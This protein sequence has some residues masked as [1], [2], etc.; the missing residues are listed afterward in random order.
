MAA[1]APKKRGGLKPLS[2]RIEMPRNHWLPTLKYVQVATHSRCN[3]DCSFCPYVESAHAA[4][5]GMMTDA[6]WHKILSNLVP[7][8]DTLLKFCPY[9]M[10]EPLIDKSIFAKIDD[11]YRVFPNICVEISTN[12]A[13]LTDSTIDKLLERFS[14]KKHDLWISHHGIDA[15]TL[16]H[17]MAIDYEKATAN[18]INLL[19]KADGKFNIRIRGAGRSSTT[20][21]VYFTHEQYMA[22]WEELFNTHKINRKNVHVDSFKFHDRAGTL[23][24]TDRGACDLNGGKVREI[25]PGHAPFYCPRINDWIHFM[26]DGSL[27]MCC[28][29]Y[30]HEVKLPNINNMSLLTYYHSPE[31]AELA[32]KVSGRIESEENFICKRCISPGG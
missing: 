9:L 11:I 13:A 21:R 32:G 4:R 28:M 3:A 26:Y 19:K 17:I 31:Y 22:H 6:T 29:D 20:D 30:H 18:L 5:P 12:G 27:R 2:P 14:G 8:K 15:Q 16:E 7:W 10:Q 23:H 1:P 25:G 24:R